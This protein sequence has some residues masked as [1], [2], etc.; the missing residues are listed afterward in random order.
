MK[1]KKKKLRIRKLQERLGSK[2]DDLEQL[3][4]LYAQTIQQ[5]KQKVLEK[6]QEIKVKKM[7]E[8]HAMDVAMTPK[9]EGKSVAINT[10]LTFNNNTCNHHSGNLKEKILKDK[11]S[12]MDT[13]GVGTSTKIGD[14]IIYDPNK[15]LFSLFE[16]FKVLEEVEGKFLLDYLHLVDKVDFTAGD[17]K[18]FNLFYK[19]FRRGEINQEDPKSLNKY[20]EFDLTHE[21]KDK[22]RKEWWAL[23]KYKLMKLI[24]DKYYMIS[25]YLKPLLPNDKTKNEYLKTFFNVKNFGKSQKS[26]GTE[27]DVLSVL[28]GLRRYYKDLD[29]RK[30]TTREDSYLPPVALKNNLLTNDIKMLESISENDYQTTKNT[31]IRDIRHFKK[32][33]RAR[34]KQNITERYKFGL[35]N[36]N[37]SGEVSKGR[38]ANDFI[39]KSTSKLSKKKF[40]QRLMM[41]DQLSD[42]GKDSSTRSDLIAHGTG[43]ADQYQKS[44]FAY[45]SFPNERIETMTSHSNKQ[46]TTASPPS[47]NDKAIESRNIHLISSYQSIDIPGIVNARSRSTSMKEKVKSK[48]F[49]RGR[50]PQKFAQVSKYPVFTSCETPLREKG[51]PPHQ[52]KKEIIH[53]LGIDQTEIEEAIKL[54]PSSETLHCSNWNNYLTEDH[55]VRAKKQQRRNEYWNLRVLPPDLS[56]SIYK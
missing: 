45:E 8:K 1:D 4:K 2:L 17:E 36:L 32:A 24:N 19:N 18:K 11:L 26:V 46:I 54:K 33:S 42:S 53:R 20:G 7:A 16:G 27:P 50:Q 55:I 3:E 47:R 41:L 21:L 23:T 40:V 22:K 5:E 28:E 14:C 9:P 30:L 51:I 6:E 25:K 48:G 52:S 44:R 29:E 39:R 13:G 15:P 43:H 37:Q 35:Q 38:N 34:S 56:P 49:S 10:D 12:K 31:R